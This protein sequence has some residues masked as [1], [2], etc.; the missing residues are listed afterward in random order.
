MFQKKIIL[1]GKEITFE[2][3]KIANQADG[4]IIVK[5]EETIVLVTVVADRKF[6]PGNDF[7]P[8][9][10]DY[11]EKMSAAGLIPGGIGKREGRPKDYEILISRLIDRS[12]RPLF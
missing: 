12:I 3:G 5:S 1:D 11:Q 2:T 10:V 4:A 7:L 9:T 6:K 8:L